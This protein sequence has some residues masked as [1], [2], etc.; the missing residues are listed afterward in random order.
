MKVAVRD[1]KIEQAIKV[2]KRKMQSEGIFRQM[3]ECEFFEKPS[4]KRKRKEAEAVRRHKKEL[5]KRD[6]IDF[7][8]VARAKGR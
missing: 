7:G 6:D 2:L 3:R 1:G 8:R 4:E 5:R